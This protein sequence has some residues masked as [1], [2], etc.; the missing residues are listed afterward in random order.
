MS[1]IVR[2]ALEVLGF[3]LFPGQAAILAEIYDDAIRTGV[4]R[5]G[6]RSGKGRLAAV[7]ATFE[8]TVNAEAHL[9]AVPP[10][11]RVAVVIVATNQKQAGIVHGYVR[12]FLHRPELAPLIA[13]E[14][15]NEI[16]LTNGIVILTVP[17]HAASVRGLAIAVLVLDEAA[18][19]TGV[20]GS[21]L[22]VAEVWDALVPAT[23]QF[24]EA[25]ILV[26]STPRSDGGW[27][28]DLCERAASG[29]DPGLRAWH[30][31]TAEMN[32]RISVSL[33]ERQRLQDPDAFRREYEAE[34]DAGVGAVFDANLVR[35]AVR[36][37]PEILPPRP[38]TVYV[39]ALDPAFTG[40][41]FAAIVGHAEDERVVIDAVRGWH[42]T[43]GAPVRIDPTLDQIA[44]LAR[45]YGG[46]PVVTDQYAAEPIRQGL[47]AR[48]VSVRAKAWTSETKIDAVAALRGRLA[49][50]TLELPPNSILVNELIGFEQRLLPSARPRFAAAHGGHD[51]FAT[52]LL[53]LVAELAGAAWTAE[54]ED[55]ARGVWRC[56]AC[57]HLFGW[58]PCKSCPRC[59]KRAPRRYGH[60]VPPLGQPFPEE[61]EGCP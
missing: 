45:A 31:T 35:A 3:V 52:A 33:L 29:V 1:A 7:V 58:D 47:A 16:E 21:P 10:G 48:G 28:A 43:R 53:A 49:V 46:A 56:R 37:G 22:D 40:D 55:F 26:L 2:F 8:A 61:D 60:Q 23:A 4:L 51:D 14:T 19:F 39:V 44:E 41:A 13:R 57:G 5:L 50:G 42:G 9:A 27:F 24:P 6:R 32:P 36:G 18:W 59:R 25:R 54:A 30:A 15:A 34:F 17:C 20:D 11:E 38:E 12:G